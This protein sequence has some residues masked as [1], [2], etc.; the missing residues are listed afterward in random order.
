MTKIVRNT[1]LELLRILKIHEN[2]IFE[3]AIENVYEIIYEKK[4]KNNLLPLNMYLKTLV[5]FKIKKSLIDERTFIIG[6][7][8]MLKNLVEI[9]DD[10]QSKVN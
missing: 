5:G 3:D 2:G 8:F 6:K 10:R 4:F 7:Q 1:T 9:E